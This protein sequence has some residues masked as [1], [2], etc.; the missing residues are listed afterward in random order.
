MKN[1]GYFIN[2]ETFQN[3]YDNSE[4]VCANMAVIQMFCKKYKN[5][6][7]FGNIVPLINWNVRISDVLY[8]DFTNIK[9]G[10]IIIEH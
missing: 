10:K 6:D 1:T 4:K 5:I 9:N 7:E 3:M 2:K 8:A